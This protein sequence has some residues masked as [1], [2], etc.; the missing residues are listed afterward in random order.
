MQIFI[1]FIAC[2]WLCWVNFKYG[3]TKAI[4]SCNHKILVND[5]LQVRNCWFGS[6][7]KKKERFSARARSSS[8]CTC[9]ISLSL[10]ILFFLSE[11]FSETFLSLH[12]A[13]YITHKFVINYLLHFCGGACGC[14]C[15]HLYGNLC[16]WIQKIL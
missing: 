11:A 2:S 7:T 3:E 10:S 1:G 13:L 8:S 9:Q 15:V 16:V 14:G 5:L 4:S 12:Y 6:K